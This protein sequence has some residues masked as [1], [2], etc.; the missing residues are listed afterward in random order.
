MFRCRTIQQCLKEIKSMD[1]DTAITE[2]FIRVL[3]KE[4]KVLN[5]RSGTKFLVDFDDLVLY[6][7]G[8]KNQRKN[9]EVE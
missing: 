6:L 5:F 9:T 3:C 8:K 7:S 4:N 1:E 2:N